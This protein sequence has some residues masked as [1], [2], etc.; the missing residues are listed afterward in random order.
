MSYFPNISKIKYEGASSTNPYAYKFYNPAEKLGD[1]T[2]EE[3]LR[4]G[5]SYWHT[6]TMDGSD[7]FGAGTMI[8]PWDKYSDL[9][10]AKARV[11]ASFEFYEKLDVPFFCFHDVDI[12]PEGSN[13]R[14]TNKNLDI[15]VSM[16]K[17]YMKDSK[18]KLLWNTANNFTHPRFVHGAATSS[19]A[20]VRSEEHTSELQSR[21][22]LVC[23]LLLEIKKKY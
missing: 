12:S 18:A 20:D 1:K 5:V 9:D 13:L 16:I 22:H 2:M 19:N 8:R 10:L 23:R 11:D 14:E 6:F 15:I 4:F 21:G 17:D 7:P 3:I